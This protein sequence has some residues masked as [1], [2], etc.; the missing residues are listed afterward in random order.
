MLENVGG[1][2]AEWIASPDCD[3][4][5]ERSRMWILVSLKVMDSDGI[6]KYLCLSLILC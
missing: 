5:A 6:C 2:V 3:R 1:E 4:E